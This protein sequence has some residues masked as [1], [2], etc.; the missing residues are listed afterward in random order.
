MSYLSSAMK[1]LDILMTAANVASTI[2]SLKGNPKKASEEDVEWPRIP[3]SNDESSSGTFMR[4]G[5]VYVTLS[6][7]DPRVIEYHRRK[8][9]EAARAERRAEECAKAATVAEKLKQQAINAIE[10]VEETFNAF[11]DKVNE[12]F[13]EMEE[14]PQ[15]DMFEKKGYETIEEPSS[16]KSLLDRV[17]GFC[18]ELS[19]HRE[20]IAQVCNIAKDVV[21]V[22]ASIA[23]TF[24][25]VKFGS[26]FS[27]SAATA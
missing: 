16:K 20:T 12:V 9:E 13:P 26:G 27:P 2:K 3:R 11:A 15:A 23:A 14:N 4:N 7:N 5:K 22:A 18:V 10:G 24:R 25:N 8:A 17:L 21:Q 6:E 1:A 19:K